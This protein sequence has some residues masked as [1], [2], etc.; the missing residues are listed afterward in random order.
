MLS[1]TRKIDHALLW[2]T[3]QQARLNAYAPYSGFLVGAAVC[4]GSGNIYSGGNIENASYGLTLCA[5]RSAI[6]QAISQ[7]EK[8]ILAVAIAGGKTPCPPCGMC[9]QVLAE[10]GDDNLLVILGKSDRQ[11]C[12]L[13]LLLPQAF[14]SSIFKKNGKHSG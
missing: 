2:K 6:A 13:G 12:S 7:G 5:E 8:R 1:M 3:A 10:F 4:G 11:V 9:R 14:R